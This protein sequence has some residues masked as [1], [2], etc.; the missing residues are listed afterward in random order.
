MVRDTLTKVENAPDVIKKALETG[1]FR[2]DHPTEVMFAFDQTCNLSCPSCRTERITEKVSQSLAK[3]RA[4]E[5]KFSPLLSKARIL[6]INPAGELFASKPSRKILEMINDDATPDIKLAIISNGTLF[7]EQEWNKYPGIHNRIHSIR[8]SI[9]AA[10]KETF[11]KLRR[12]G[13]YDTFVKN[14]RFLRHLRMTVIPQLKFSFTYQIDNFKEM[15]TFVDFCA[16]MHAD[17]AIFER[18]QNITFT[19]DEYLEKAVHRP[20]HRLFGEF[21]DTINEPK[22]SDAR[23]WHDFD[24]PGFVGR[25]SND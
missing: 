10:S 16:E 24:F 8:I 12:L 1:D 11:E 22:M 5:E 7:T 15:P 9:D 25:K 14:M 18:L 19:A 3:A 4:V 20:S 2:I 23:C 17:Y 21:I 6:H 13:N